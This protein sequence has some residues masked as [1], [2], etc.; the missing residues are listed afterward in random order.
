MT[1]TKENAPL[2]ERSVEVKRDKS[3]TKPTG[4]DDGLSIPANVHKENF[5]A[6]PGE[7]VHFSKVLGLTRDLLPVVSDPNAK[8]SEY[9]TVKDLAGC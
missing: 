3:G 6:A 2:A 7:W 4:N 8:I 9:S 1:S 5:G